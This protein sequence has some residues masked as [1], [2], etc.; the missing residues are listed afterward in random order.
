MEPKVELPPCGAMKRVR[1]VPTWVVMLGGGRRE[2]AAGRGGG[3][4]VNAGT[5]SSKRGPNS[6]GWLGKTITPWAC[7]EGEIL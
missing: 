2:G 1:G 7:H 6:T 3:G 4:G 5:V